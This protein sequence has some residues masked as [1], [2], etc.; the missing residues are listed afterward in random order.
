MCARMLELTLAKGVNGPAAGV[1]VEPLQGSGGMIPLPK[2][3]LQRV[4]EI[5]DEFEVPLIFDEIQTYMRIG[6]FTAAEYYGVEPDMIALGKALGGGL[7]LG[8]TVI[9]DGLEG[10]GPDTE[11]LHT[12]AANTLAMVGATKLI[13]IVERDHV[14][15]NTVKMG[16][17]LRNGLLRIQQDYPEVADIRQVGLHIGVEFAA[18]DAGRTPLIAETRKIRDEAMKRGAIFGLTGAMKNLLKIKPPLIINEAE[19][20][21]VLA[22]LERAL[23]AVLR[24]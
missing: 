5:C 20:N 15:D 8:A 3:Y 14:L 17:H 12:F 18:P 21:E 7:P 1:I 10:F 19:A 13:D 24:P 4:R 23:M 2:R 9:R 22:I 11:E 6:K 16:E